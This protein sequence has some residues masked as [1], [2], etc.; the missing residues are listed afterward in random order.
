MYLSLPHN[1]CSKIEDAKGCPRLETIFVK[2]CYKLSDRSLLA[3]GKN[4]HYLRRID[5]SSCREMTD[6]G[7]KI[8]VK[9]CK[10]LVNV[11][12]SNPEPQVQE[13]QLQRNVRLWSQHNSTKK[14]IG[15]S[16]SLRNHVWASKSSWKSILPNEDWMK[17]KSERC[18]LF[19]LIRR[20]CTSRQNVNELLFVFRVIQAW[21]QL[22][23]GDYTD[24]GKCWEI[25]LKEWTNLWSQHSKKTW[26]TVNSS[27]FM[28]LRW[29][30]VLRLVDTLLTDVFGYLVITFLLKSSSHH[31]CAFN[32][33]LW[34]MQQIPIQTKPIMA[35]WQAWK[36]LNVLLRCKSYPHCSQSLRG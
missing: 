15:C 4:C 31:F 25:Y 1:Y 17:F 32:Q 23:Y 5:I 22:C 19:R 26:W 35:F 10:L 29:N 6:Y 18:S 3:I 21:V 2:R 27:H 24:V 8:L 36:P 12:F 34:L 7:I 13:E 9:G 33:L 11:D 14:W 20:C 28:Y 16:M 30:Y